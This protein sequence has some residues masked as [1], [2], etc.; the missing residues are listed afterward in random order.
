MCVFL[1]LFS[2]FNLV[3]VCMVKVTGFGPINC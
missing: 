1:R 3:T 2:F